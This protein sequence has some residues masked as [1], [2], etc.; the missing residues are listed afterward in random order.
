MSKPKPKCP[1]CGSKNL[2][3]I[4]VDPPLTRCGDCNHTLGPA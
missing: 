4:P 2:I 3:T 1:N